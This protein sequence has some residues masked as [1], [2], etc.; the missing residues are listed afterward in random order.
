MTG[1]SSQTLSHSPTKSS[2]GPRSSRAESGSSSPTR[3]QSRRVSPSSSGPRTTSLW[4]RSTSGHASR[5]SSVDSALL[6]RLGS[7]RSPH[8][9]GKRCD[10]TEDSHEEKDFA[11]RVD[12]EVQLRGVELDL[13]PGEDRLKGADWDVRRHYREGHPKTEQRPRVD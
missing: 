11:H 13:H 2:R 9:G 4:S 1:W 5:P 6:S 7:S 12:E 3:R 10:E 8:R